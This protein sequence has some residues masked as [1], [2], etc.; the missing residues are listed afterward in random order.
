MG[1]PGTNVPSPPGCSP[2]LPPMGMAEAALA[3]LGQERGLFPLPRFCAPK[4]DSGTGHVGSRCRKRAGRIL[5]ANT[6]L[7]RLEQV[8][9]GRLSESVDASPAPAPGICAFVWSSIGTGDVLLDLF[10]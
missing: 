1:L 3:G 6:V 9:G 8:L 2:D 5:E 10:A 4:R 7:A